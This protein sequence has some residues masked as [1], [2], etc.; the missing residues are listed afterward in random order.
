MVEN[1]TIKGSSL[2]NLRTDYG[3]TWQGEVIIKN[4]TFVPRSNSVNLIAGSYSG[5]HDFGYTCYMTTTVTIDGL[6]VM[7]GNRTNTEVN[8]FSN[9]NASYTSE[10]YVEDYPYVM[11]ETVTVTGYESEKN[12]PL[13]ISPNMYMFRNTEL[14]KK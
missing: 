12:S 14:I 2:V 6:K 11:P 1:S 5:K 8:V 13:Y 7:D 10:A 3:S 4:C 9:P